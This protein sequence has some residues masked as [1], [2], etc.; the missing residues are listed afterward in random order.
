M[1]PGWNR[2]DFLRTATHAF[3]DLGRKRLH[4][5][6]VREKS[7]KMIHCSLPSVLPFFLSEIR[8]AGLQ[9]LSAQ[10]RPRMQL[11]DT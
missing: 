4:R 8:L 7:L 9:H 2:T 10:Q 5:L 3:A 1:C 6:N 11:T